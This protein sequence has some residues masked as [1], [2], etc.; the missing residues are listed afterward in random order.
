MEIR[1]FQD[2]IRRTY[3]EKDRARGMEATFLWLIEEVGELATAL[4]EG[5]RE[6]RAAEFA[7]VYAWLMTL[8]N[9]ADVDM[10]QALTKYSAGCCGCGKI[11][12]AC[13]PSAKP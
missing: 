3:Y 10:E 1:A 6:E 9:L 12:C 8:A 7:D 11:P 5:T 4:R 2:I 13:P